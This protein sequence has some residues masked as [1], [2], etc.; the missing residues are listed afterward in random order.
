MVNIDA[1]FDTVKAPESEGTVF[2]YT[3]RPAAYENVQNELVF[4]WGFVE[5]AV[6]RAV[7]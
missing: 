3:D 1:N 7:H 2:R 5:A 6:S 4:K